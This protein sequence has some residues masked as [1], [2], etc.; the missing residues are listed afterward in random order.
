MRV[1]KDRILRCY[2]NL[3]CAHV[4]E[5]IFQRSTRGQSYIAVLRRQNAPWLIPPFHL[6]RGKKF[7]GYGICT[8]I[9]LNLGGVW[10]EFAARNRFWIRALLSFADFFSRYFRFAV[11]FSCGLIDHDAVQSMLSK[12]LQAVEN[13][14]VV[15]VK[16][17][18]IG[19][20]Q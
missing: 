3:K 12:T 4:L 2:L 10:A 16:D 11:C 18:R 13:A 6:M 1:F 17:E 5:I 19:C 15:Q 14:A 20:S 9:Q 8:Q 7:F